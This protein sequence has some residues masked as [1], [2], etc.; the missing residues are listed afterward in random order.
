[1]NAPELVTIVLQGGSS[2][3]DLRNL[4]A[5]EAKD[6]YVKLGRL[7]VQ[8]SSYCRVLTYLKQC[9]VINLVIFFQAWIYQGKEPAHFLQIFKGRMIT[10]VGS[11]TDYDRKI[12]FTL[13]HCSTAST[14]QSDSRRIFKSICLTHTC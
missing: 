1:M 11:A 9:A 13:N 7:P 14:P 4:G 5:K 12:Y 8:V 3:N 6:L 2:P 10:Y